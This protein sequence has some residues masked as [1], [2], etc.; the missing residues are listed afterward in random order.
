MNFNQIRQAMGQVGQ[1]GYFFYGKGYQC[2][3]VS[4][5]KPSRMGMFREILRLLEYVPRKER[6]RCKR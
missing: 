1:D 3:G 6:I 5:A 2:R 4:S